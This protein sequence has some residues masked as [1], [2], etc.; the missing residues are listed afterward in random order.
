VRSVFGIHIYLFTTRPSLAAGRPPL[1]RQR[2]SWGVVACLVGA[3]RAGVAVIC[4]RAGCAVGRT[5][6]HP[7]P[8]N[9]WM[10]GAGGGPCAHRTVSL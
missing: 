1:Q 9:R 7:R 10:G 2:A 5:H 8:S 4:C 6:A 3:P